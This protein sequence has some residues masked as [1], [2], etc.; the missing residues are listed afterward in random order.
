M[1]LSTFILTSYLTLW[2]IILLYLLHAS[3]IQVVDLSCQSTNLCERDID[4]KSSVLYSN[5]KYINIIIIFA[6]S[7][8]SLCMYQET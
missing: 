2:A 7:N 8:A 1:S 5:A 3:L 4:L 6:C